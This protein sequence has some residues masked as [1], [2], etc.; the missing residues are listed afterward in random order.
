MT[1]RLSFRLNSRRY[2]ATPQ[3]SALTRSS[4]QRILEP[5]TNKQGW[6]LKECDLALCFRGA[7]PGKASWQSFGD[8]ATPR[9]PFSVCLP[10]AREERQ[11]RGTTGNDGYEAANKL[12]VASKVEVWVSFIRVRGEFSQRRH[13]SAASTTSRTLTGLSDRGPRRSTTCRTS[14][15]DL[16]LHRQ[17][18]E[19]SARH[20][21]AGTT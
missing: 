7:A 14:Q 4:G 2:E 8:T 11:R 13:S 16:I 21:G 12:S 3:V 5:V 20:H 6:T 17:P 15:A 1:V 19:S 9:H 18:A 10:R